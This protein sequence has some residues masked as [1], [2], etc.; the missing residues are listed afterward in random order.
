M[1]GMEHNLYQQAPGDAAW[2]ARPLP[3]GLARDA[4]FV[5]P[6]VDTQG[7]EIVHLAWWAV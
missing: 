2:G 5:R 4:W 3:P 7:H 1:R 6:R